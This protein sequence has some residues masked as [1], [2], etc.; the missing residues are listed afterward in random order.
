MIIE[1]LARLGYASKALIYGIVGT[2]AVMAALNRGG[3]ITDT[4]GALKVVLAQPFGRI[5]LLVLACGLCGY[6]IWRLLDAI[7]DPDRHGAGAKGIVVRVGNVVRGS[8]YGMLGVEAFRLFQGLG[9]SEGDEAK[10]WTARILDVP[11]GEVLIGLVG[12]IVAL[13]GVSQIVDAVRGKHDASLDLSAIPSN[14]R[15]AVTAISRFGVGARGGIIAT[16]GVLLAKAA[17]EHDP[18]EAAGSR[19]STLELAAVAD[20][21]WLLALIAAGLLAYALDQVVHARCRRI[22]PVV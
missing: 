9:G 21:R 10:I 1:N 17:L 19:E 13:Y 8:I 15:A 14:A 16:I 2:L 12:I 6:A 22:R 11:F 7:R 18:G 4:S 3:Q 20:G 5:L